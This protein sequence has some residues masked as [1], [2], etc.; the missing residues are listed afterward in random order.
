MATVDVRLVEGG[1]S[2]LY[3]S[4]LGR[5]GG[6]RA[7][8]T[9]WRPARARSV[10][11]QAE[12]EQDAETVQEAFTC[13]LVGTTE[14]I[15]Q[16]I[17]DIERLLVLGERRRKRGAGARVYVE[18]RITLTGS[19]YRSPVLGGY[20]EYRDSLFRYELIGGTAEITVVV[21][22]MYYWEGNLQTLAISNR[23]GSSSGYLSCWNYYVASTSGRDN[24]VQIAAGAV[25]GSLPT[26]PYLTVRDT[27]GSSS[28]RIG[29]VWVNNSDVTPTLTGSVLQGTDSSLGTNTGQSSTTTGTVKA[30]DIVS[31]AAEAS[32]F[33]IPISGAFLASLQEAT[34]DLIASFAP[35]PAAPP[36]W[37][38]LR[39]AIT[40]NGTETLWYGDWVQGGGVHY[41]ELG[42]T[43]LPPAL[44]GTGSTPGDLQLS[45][46]GRRNPGTSLYTVYLDQVMV[47]PRTSYRRYRCGAFGIPASEALFDDAPDGNLYVANAT[48]GSGRRTFHVGAGQ[49]YLTPGRAQTLYVMHDLRSFGGWSALR[50]FQVQVRYRPRRA[51]I[52]EA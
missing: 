41:L 17:R 6:S 9:G 16:T 20:V 30:G 48:T 52:E 22:R 19:Y 46:Y 31:D 27:T 43:R 11:D 14:E 33:R 38:S 51:S 34:C 42:T 28:D 8:L 29:S 44:M 7:T 3:L 45:I 18:A 10:I 21:E 4:G 47:L 26:P 5:I 1:G 2:P 25:Q 15:R 12:L 39:A 24:Y 36:S 35:I 32:L 13:T 49:I 40:Y 23:N 50:Q 37:V